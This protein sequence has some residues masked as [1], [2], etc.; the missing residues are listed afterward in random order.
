MPLD[1]E[2]QKRVEE[3]MEDMKLSMPE[4]EWNSITKMAKEAA[5]RNRIKNGLPPEPDSDESIH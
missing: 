1:P 3:L 5:N 4:D 2:K